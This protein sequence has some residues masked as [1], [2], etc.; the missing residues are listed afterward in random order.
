MTPKD[1]F[2]AWSKGVRFSVWPEYKI[3]FGNFFGG[4]LH[5]LAYLLKTE[6]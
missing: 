1:D 3:N 6:H 4:C 2:M 5:L